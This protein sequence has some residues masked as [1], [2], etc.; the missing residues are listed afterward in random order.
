MT[1]K[2]ASKVLNQAAKYVLIMFGLAFLCIAVLTLIGP[3][4]Q[5]PPVTYQWT[6]IDSTTFAKTTLD[7]S[8]T[9]SQI[10]WSHASSEIAY[11]VE[12][13]YG[14]ASVYVQTIDEDGHPKWFRKRVLISERNIYDL[15]WSPDGTR[16]AYIE[17]TDYRGKLYILDVESRIKHQLGDLFVTHINW[18]PDGES[19][20]ATTTGG[21]DNQVLHV[22]DAATGEALLVAED[23]SFD[24]PVWSYDSEWI[25]FQ[26][27]GPQIHNLYRVRRDGSDTM[28]VT[29]SG[30]VEENYQWSSDGEQILFEGVNGTL[31]AV[32]ITGIDGSGV[33]AIENA[34]AAAECP[35]WSPDGKL[36]L[37][38]A[39]EED[40]YRV[41]LYLM[42]MAD[43][44]ITEIPDAFHRD[45]CP[46]WSPDGRFIIQLTK[47]T[48]YSS[49]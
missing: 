48:N 33:H 28:Q 14:G 7:V 29:D 16:L 12:S 32:Y 3:N 9:T 23:A 47:T 39:T 45:T 38:A 13:Q 11:V 37:F 25:L 4:L 5:P 41:R 2:K 15:Q 21:A 10:A 31:R 8:N 18:S 44:T 36:I 20:A 27:V 30:V 22:I 43:G 1:V 6:L 17:G 40:S 24:R 26:S 42:E 49:E 35:A 19:I 46:T 34:G